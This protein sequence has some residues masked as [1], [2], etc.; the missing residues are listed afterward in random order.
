MHLISSA[1]VQEQIIKQEIELQQHRLALA[2]LTDETNRYK[3]QMAGHHSRL[4]GSE[5][6]GSPHHSRVQGSEG[7]GSP[8]QS[9]LHS[10]DGQGS[11]HNSRTS[12]PTKI[13]QTGAVER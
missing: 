12:T 4:Q 9:R 1:A 6:P 3:K 13:Q 2:N 10:G 7:P 5:G 8:R 11:P